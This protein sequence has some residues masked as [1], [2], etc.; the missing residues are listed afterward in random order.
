MNNKESVVTGTKKYEQTHNSMQII[1]E[2]RQVTL[3]PEVKKKISLMIGIV[4][5]KDLWFHWESGQL[6]I[7]DDVISELK[8]E[9]PVIDI[10][11][12]N[13]TVYSTDNISTSHI[14]DLIA[15]HIYSTKP[16]MLMCEIRFTIKYDDHID[17]HTFNPEF[18]FPKC[19]LKEW[20]NLPKKIRAKY[21]LNEQIRPRF[22]FLTKHKK[23]IIDTIIK[24][25]IPIIIGIIIIYAKYIISGISS[26]IP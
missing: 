1:C 16:L 3:H 6:K 5:N 26:F 14:I 18:N 11:P 7:N 17:S 8:S 13:I 21:Y 9:M 4:A 12:N 15:S 24:A 25:I 19:E 22:D 20:L 23:V 10:I 2:I